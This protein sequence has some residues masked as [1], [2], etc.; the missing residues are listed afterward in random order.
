VEAH[1]A[2]LMKKLGTN[3]IADLF[4]LVLGSEP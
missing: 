2:S 4:R 1:R 3:N